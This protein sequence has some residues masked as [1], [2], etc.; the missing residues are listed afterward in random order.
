M[1]QLDPLTALQISAAS[2][3]DRPAAVVR[4]LVDNAIDAGATRI[5][6]TVHNG[7]IHVTDDGCGMTSHE[8]QQAFLRHTTSKIQ[9]YDDIHSVTTLG[10]RGEALAN[11][12]AIA[13]VTCVSRARGTAHAYEL[14]MAAG[15]FHD[16]R[17]CA[18]SVG[19]T[20]C[21]ERLYYTAPQ[22]RAFWRQPAHELQL[23]GDVVARYAVLFPHIAFRAVLGD[24]LRYDTSGSGDMATCVLELWQ[25]PIRTHIDATLPSSTITVHGVL[26]ADTAAAPLRRRQIV[27]INQRPIATRG[28]VAH[29]ID[30]LMPP[31]HTHYPALVLHLTLPR[32]MVDINIKSSKEEVGVRT[33][34]VVARALYY[35]LQPRQMTVFDGALPA[36]PFPTYHTLGYFH[37]YVVAQSEDSIAICSPARIMQACTITHLPHGPI[38]VPPYPL[39]ARQWHILAPHQQALAQFGCMVVGTDAHTGV[40]THLPACINQRPLSTNIARMVAH[41]QH[42]ADVQQAIATLIDGDTLLTWLHQHPTPWQSQ[43]LYVMSHHKIT[44]ALRPR[45]STAESDGWQ[46]PHPPLPPQSQ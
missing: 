39:T 44:A 7:T 4:E 26:M 22:R 3:I 20:V 14:R 11:I 5:D 24:D 41:L 31:Q 6:I 35:A 27:A 36:L 18:G 28:M 30:E 25:A 32:D 29:I 37:D 46:S 9:Q 15:E 16:M 34:S 1:H 12:A 13:R 33:P 2:T 21:V 40:I 8:L 42:D 23:I 19:T 17:I 45:R 43:A 38:L 10:F